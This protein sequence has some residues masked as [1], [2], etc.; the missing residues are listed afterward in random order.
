MLPVAEEPGSGA[1]SVFGGQLLISSPYGA[2]CCRSTNE[3]ILR[4]VEALLQ[5]RLPQ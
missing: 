5:E 3:M 1:L 2:D 4:R